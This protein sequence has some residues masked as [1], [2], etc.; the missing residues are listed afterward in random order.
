MV[1]WQE[2]MDLTRMRSL[3]TCKGCNEALLCCRKELCVEEEYERDVSVCLS[4]A[5]WLSLTFQFISLD[6]YE[7]IHVHA[8]VFGRQLLY[9]CV[10]CVYCVCGW[11]DTSRSKI[12]ST[13]THTKQVF[14]FA[15]LLL[16]DKV[17]GSLW[18]C[19][20]INLQIYSHH[21]STLM[22]HKS[23]KFRSP[24]RQVSPLFLSCIDVTQ[25]NTLIQVLVEKLVSGWF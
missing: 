3:F 6:I 21:C 2:G 13:I 22:K 4:L 19:S 7:G 9:W 24:H 16:W 20:L 12:A 11:K 1:G 5:V 25:W 10:H 14:N 23:S 15:E 18:L 8:Y 17:F